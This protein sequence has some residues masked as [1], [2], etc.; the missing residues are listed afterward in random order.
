MRIKI[1]LYVS[2][3][4]LFD[5][6]LYQCTAICCNIA[7]AQE[8]EITY[9]QQLGSKGSGD[10]QFKSPHS[11]AVDRFGNIYAIQGISV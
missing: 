2:I 5:L 1:L 11:L 4:A 7:Y 8:P 9:K 10:G 6:F 3:I